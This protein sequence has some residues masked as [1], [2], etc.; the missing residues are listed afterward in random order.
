MTNTSVINVVFGS[1]RDSLYLWVYG[2]DLS[3]FVAIR[4]YVF[5]VV[6]SSFYVVNRCVSGERVIAGTRFGIIKIIY[7]NS[8][9]G[10]YAR[11]SFGVVINGGKSFTISGQRGW[12]FASGVLMSFVVEISDGHNV[13]WGYFKAN[14]YGLRVSTTVFRKVSWVPGVTFLF[15]VLGLN[16]QGKYRAVKTPIGSALATMG[17][18]FFMG[19]CGRL[20]GN[21]IATLVWDGTFSI[22]IAEE[23]RLFGLF[24]GSTTML[25]FPIPDAFWRSIATSIFLYSALFARFFGG[26]YFYYSKYIID[27]KGPWNIGTLRALGASWGVLWDIVGNISRI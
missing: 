12:N 21:F 1:S 26:F 2:G 9:G 6:I 27:A 18:A 5:K 3:Y 10:A 15:F 22:P 19:S 17:G 25:F 7:E 24:G 14:Y 23:T 11:I 8:F 13:T 20:I 4:S 16:V